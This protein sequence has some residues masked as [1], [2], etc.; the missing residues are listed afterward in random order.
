MA[1]YKVTY[2]TQTITKEGLVNPENCTSISFENVGGIDVTINTDIVCSAM[3][4]VIEFKNFPNCIIQDHF[5]IKQD[6][7]VFF[8]NPP[9]LLLDDLK[10][11]VIKTF[12][13]EIR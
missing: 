10:I 5:M 12:Y 3:G 2:K 7:Q 1:K 8:G 13:T 11:I 6:Y 4:R 9:Q